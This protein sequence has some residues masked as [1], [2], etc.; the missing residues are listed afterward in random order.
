MNLKRRLFDDLS[1]WAKTSDRRP[2]LLRGARQVG[3]TWAV[4]EWCR[5]ESRKLVAINFE[6]QPQFARL[7]ETDLNVQRIVDEI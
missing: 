4:E 5:L 2:L 3:K 6:E 7:F 1:R